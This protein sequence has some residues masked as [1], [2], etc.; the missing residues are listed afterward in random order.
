MFTDFV[1]RVFKDFDEEYHV[2]DLVYNPQWPLYAACDYGWTNPFVWILIQVDAFGN[3]YVLD[4]LRRT[5]TDINDIAREL[6]TWHG[7]L[8]TKARKFYPD[9]ASPGDTAILESKLGISADSDTGGELKFRLEQIRQFLKLGPEHA[10]P[11]IAKPRLFIDRKCV[12]GIKEM[13]DYRYPEHKN[14]D[15]YAPEEPLKKD[16]HFPE[17]LGRFFRGYY[18]A[19]AAGDGRARL[20]QA[21]YA[22]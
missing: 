4:E 10:T 1:G 18:G 20:N 9:P 12:H 14:E 8:S 11:D 7:G 6:L 17:A 19:P 5:R 22:A 16:D 21:R 3:V 15:K 2:Q 13:N